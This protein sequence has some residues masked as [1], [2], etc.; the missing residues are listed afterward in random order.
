MKKIIVLLIVVFIVSCKSS[1][2]IIGKWVANSSEQNMKVISEF[3]KDGIVEVYYYSK[4]NNQKLSDKPYLLEYST[5]KENKKWNLKFLDL[6]SNR[7]ILSPL[8]LKGKDTLITYHKTTSYKDNDTIVTWDK[9]VMV[10]FK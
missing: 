9:D 8:E 3:K 1:P 5:Y 7:E 2:N 10:R 4:V 6:Q